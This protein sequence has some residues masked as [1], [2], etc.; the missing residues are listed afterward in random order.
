[1]SKMFQISEDDLATLERLCPS[2]GWDLFPVIARM[3]GVEGG[4][5]R[6]RAQL[7]QV[8]TILSNVR[9]MYGPP[10]NCEE[11]RLED[12]GEPQP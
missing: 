6:V 9:W 10:T 5:N 3:E 1:M 11:T 2:L 4:A 8:Q 12:F 7:R